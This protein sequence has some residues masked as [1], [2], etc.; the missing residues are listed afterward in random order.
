MNDKLIRLAPFRLSYSVHEAAMAT[1]I[2]RTT[3][4]K[5]IGDGTLPSTKIGG[6]RLIR[7]ADLDRML[8]AEALSNP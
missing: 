5:L 4:Y 1:G 6:R 7:A 8:A 3:L 2:G